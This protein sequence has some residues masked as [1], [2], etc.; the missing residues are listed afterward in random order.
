[1]RGLA[2]LSLFHV[3]ISLLMSSNTF[4]SALGR[5][6]SATSTL[7]VFTSISGHELN[8]SHP[9][10]LV[11]INSLRSFANLASTSQVV[12]IADDIT[13]CSSEHLSTLNIHPAS[14]YKSE[15]QQEYSRPTM[16]FVLKTMVRLTPQNFDAMYVNG[17]M[18]L[19]ALDFDDSYTKVRLRG[20]NYVI[21]GKRYDSN[22]TQLVDFDDASSVEKFKNNARE[23]STRHGKYGLDYFVFSHKSL[24]IIARECPPFLV[25]VF[26][27]DN[28][29]LTAMLLR[30][31]INVYDASNAIFAL[32]Q[33]STGHKHL[34]DEGS[35]YNQDL[36]VKYVGHSYMLGNTDNIGLKLERVNNHVVIFI[37]E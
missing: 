22:L 20:S 24:K 15:L 28:S 19:F 31:E 35:S 16:K 7:V 18:M 9:K 36:A 29:V 6:V 25:G 33:G 37:P 17:D 23:G 8:D 12:I 34:L 32:H 21:T 2:V 4:F 13:M 26:R 1:V 27:W 10:H 30:R 3:I 11:T 5:T 14:C